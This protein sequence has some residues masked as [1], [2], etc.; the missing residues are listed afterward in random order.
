L[1]YAVELVFADE[2]LVGSH[3]HDWLVPSAVSGKLRL[4]R[5]EVVQLAYVRAIFQ[6]VEDGGFWPSAEAT[7]AWYAQIE[8]V[9]GDL[10]GLA[11]VVFHLV[12]HSDVLCVFWVRHVYGVKLA[13][14]A[15]Y[16]ASLV[17]VRDF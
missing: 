7:G 2:R 5:L 9:L 3:V 10:A 4:G 13:F 12:H 11:A 17:A 6:S 1:L 14:F 16:P 15:F 8:K